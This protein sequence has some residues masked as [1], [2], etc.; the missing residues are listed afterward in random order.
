MGNLA[1][2]LTAS[3][4][5][6]CCDSMVF[7]TRN[8]ITFFPFVF[9]QEAYFRSNCSLSAIDLWVWGFFLRLYLL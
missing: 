9:F 7:H 3:Q 6:K 8:G 1:V 5:M 2:Q 4:V